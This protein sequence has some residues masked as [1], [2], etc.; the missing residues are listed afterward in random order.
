MNMKIKRIV[1]MAGSIAVILSIMLAVSCATVGAKNE[2]V[3][4]VK[5]SFM[6]QDAMKKEGGSTFVENP[7]L[8]PEGMLKG[9][10]Y[11]FIVLKI[12][13]DLAS[14]SVVE[15]QAAALNPDGKAA[16][17]LFSLDEMK[18]LW[19]AWPAAE[20]DVL[21]RADRLERTYMPGLITKAPRGNT[22]W[23]LVFVGKNP[24]MRPAK[25]SVKAFIGAGAPVSF[26]YELPPLPAKK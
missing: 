4:T 20:A 13:A 22:T 23:Y 24:I 9:K 19:E 11:E 25:V 17:T 10:P 18:S 14:G 26:E 6:S 21:R 8:V 2:K 3:S 15:I 5:V 12:D 1:R 16:A 7:Y